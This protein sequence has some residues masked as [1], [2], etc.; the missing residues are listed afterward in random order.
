MCLI[1]LSDSFDAFDT[2]YTPKSAIT[3]NKNVLVIQNEDSNPTHTYDGNKV[4]INETLLKAKF[5]WCGECETNHHH[6]TAVFECKDSRGDVYTSCDEDNIKECAECGN[7]F[8]YQGRYAVDFITIGYGLKICFNCTSENYT[9]CCSCSDLVHDD[10]V[11]M[12]RDGRYCESCYRDEQQGDL[13]KVSDWSNH[14]LSYG[15]DVTEEL[16]F[17]NSHPLYGYMGV[18]YETLIYADDRYGAD[19]QIGKILDAIEKDAIATEDSSLDYQ[20]D[21]AV[22][23]EFVFKPQDHVSHLAAIKKLIDS[24]GVNA[25]ANTKNVGMHVH[26][27]RDMI[28]DLH[29]AKMVVFCNQLADDVFNYFAGRSGCNFCV[30]DSTKTKINRTTSNNDSRYRLINTDNSATVEFRFLRTSKHIDVVTQRVEF[31]LA[32]YEFCKYASC[33]DLSFESFI[34]FA[35]NSTYKMLKK[36][37]IS[38]PSLEIYRLDQDSNDAQ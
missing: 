37:V 16:N 29:L 7:N 28:T 17:G 20:L 21:G 30:K 34:K 19:E 11:Q 33:C 3:D 35:K 27:S 6:D 5:R 22:G 32:I 23:V 12:Y 38:M 2:D 9:F 8:K 4:I 15:T 13:S 25:L 26:F 24:V 14:V 10:T 18:E 36:R 31:L 1:N